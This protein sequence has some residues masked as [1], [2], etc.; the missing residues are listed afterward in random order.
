MLTGRVLLT[1]QRQAVSLRVS[2]RLAKV[3]AVITENHYS[4]FPI[5][6]GHLSADI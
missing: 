4:L 5:L 6:K 2:Q 1:S 3:D